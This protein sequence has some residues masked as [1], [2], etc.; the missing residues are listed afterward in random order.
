M[1][2]KQ[3]KVRYAG[4]RR[5]SDPARLPPLLENG[6]DAVGSE[7]GPFPSFQRRGGCALNKKIPF[8]NGADG[9]VIISNK[10]RCV[11]RIYT[12]ASRLITDHPSRCVAF[13]P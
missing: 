5:L 4:I 12:E 11:T 6:G 9:V 2:F 1:D 8:L 10:I 13:P 7:T 3:N